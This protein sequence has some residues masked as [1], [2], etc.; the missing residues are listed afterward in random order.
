MGGI[1]INDIDSIVAQGVVFLAAVRPE[2]RS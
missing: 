1:E 2:F